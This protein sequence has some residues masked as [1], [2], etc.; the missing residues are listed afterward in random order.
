MPS[1]AAAHGSS[2]LAELPPDEAAA[3]V[4][5]E[6][7]DVRVLR[8]QSVDGV[9]QEH[10]DVRARDRLERAQRGVALRGGTARD[11]ATA[12]SI[13]LDRGVL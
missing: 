7:R 8:G 3:L 9:D 10:R 11:P 6:A 2:A 4:H 5:D 12:T 13:G 1:K